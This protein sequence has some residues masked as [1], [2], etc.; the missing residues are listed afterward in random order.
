MVE[1]SL[2]LAP[3]DVE[4]AGDGALAVAGLVPRAYDLLQGWRGGQRWWL[5]LFQRWQC[6]ST[7]RT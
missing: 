7:S 4:F 6:R 3:V 5:V 1:D 2:G